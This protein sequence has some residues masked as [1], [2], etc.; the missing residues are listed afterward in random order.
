MSTASA[1]PEPRD[2]EDKLLP[3]EEAELERRFAESEEAEREGRLITWEAL[4]PPKR[5]TG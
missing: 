2:D 3:E 4:F 1:Q 5:L